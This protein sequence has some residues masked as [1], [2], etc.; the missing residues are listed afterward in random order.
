MTCRADGEGD[1]QYELLK[2]ENEAF[3]FQYFEYVVLTSNAVCF[4]RMFML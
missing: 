3:G 2:D 4:I 1:I